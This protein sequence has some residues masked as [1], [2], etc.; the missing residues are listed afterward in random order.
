MMHAGDGKA[1]RMQ[2]DVSAMLDQLVVL[3]SVV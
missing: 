2:D 3:V 1:V